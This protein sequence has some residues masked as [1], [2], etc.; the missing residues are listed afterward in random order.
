MT[1]LTFFSYIIHIKNIFAFFSSISKPIGIAFGTRLLFNNQMILKR[2]FLKNVIF[3][4]L[5]SVC[6]FVCLQTVSR[7][8]HTVNRAQT[9][10]FSKKYLEL[11]SFENFIKIG[12]YVKE[13]Y[14]FFCYYNS[15]SC[16]PLRRNCF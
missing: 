4:R 14:P 16:W 1:F 10:P 9:W 13:L 3:K 6:L 2:Q 7:L 12:P 5:F 8:N 15:V 11:Q